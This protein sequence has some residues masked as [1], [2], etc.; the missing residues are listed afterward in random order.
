[1]ETELQDKL[2]VSSN[3]YQQSTDLSH[4]LHV[5]HFMGKEITEAEKILKQWYNEDGFPVDP[6]SYGNGIWIKGEYMRPYNF[7]HD[8]V[9][10]I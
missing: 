4:E 9:T 1:M 3:A 10:S 8:K 7:L 2:F 5:V 6:L